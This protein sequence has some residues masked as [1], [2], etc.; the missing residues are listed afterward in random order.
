MS[1]KALPNVIPYPADDHRLVQASEL[2]ALKLYDHLTGRL[3]WTSTTPAHRISSNLRRSGTNSI[4]L[5]SGAESLNT[6]QCRAWFPYLNLWATRGETKYYLFTRD[7]PASILPVFNFKT[8]EVTYYLVPP[9][10]RVRTFNARF[11]R[12]LDYIL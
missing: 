12:A 4:G 1:E 6:Y 10:A 7:T 11:V 9:S 2:L 5:L 3:F 8:N